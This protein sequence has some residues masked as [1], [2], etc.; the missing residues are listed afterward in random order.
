MTLRQGCSRIHLSLFT[1]SR[2]TGSVGR[3]SEAPQLSC[4]PVSISNLLVNEVTSLLGSHGILDM[5]IGTSPA[6]RSLPRKPP[7]HSCASAPNCLQPGFRQ[8]AS[9]WFG[10][11]LGMQQVQRWSHCIEPNLRMASIEP[12]RFP[13]SYAPLHS[14]SKTEC[15]SRLREHQCGST[16]EQY[17]PELMHCCMHLWICWTGP[18]EQGGPRPR[19]V[20]MQ[21]DFHCHCKLVRHV[22]CLVR[23]YWKLRHEVRH[24]MWGSK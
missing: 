20:D 13:S 22:V 1:P 19:A 5:Q 12:S 15:L 18:N 10:L 9:Q 8:N 6:P 14:D 2:T 17:P 11:L 16:A 3:L 21:C 4:I 24:T 23:A 7:E